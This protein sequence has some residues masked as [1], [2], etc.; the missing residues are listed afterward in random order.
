MFTF[1]NKYINRQL[2]RVNKKLHSGRFVYSPVHSR[3]RYV[4]ADTNCSVSQ[5]N[6]TRKIDYEPIEMMSQSV[7]VQHLL[8]KQ[9][10][11]EQAEPILTID[12][13]DIV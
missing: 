13:E 9:V 5:A 12:S 2:R 1:I 10:N 3:N 6:T 4:E 8:Q 7:N 11:E